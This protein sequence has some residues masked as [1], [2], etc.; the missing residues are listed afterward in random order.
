MPM[1]LPVRVQGW[2]A[3]GS[4][5]EELTQSEEASVGGAS[6]YLHRP[7]RHG[8][9]LQLSMPLPE[10]MRVRDFKVAS[11]VIHALVRGVSVH[12]GTC[13]ARVMFLARR[14]PG[15]EANPGGIY[16][17]PRDRQAAAGLGAAPSPS[18]DR[19]AAARAG[20]PGP[21]TPAAAAGRRGTVGPAA[22]G[23]GAGE[24]RAASPGAAADASERRGARRV[25]R[26]VNVRV[27]RTAVG[28]GELTI[29]ENISPHGARL[30]TTLAIA[31]GE[32]VW[33]EELHGAFQTRGEVRNAYLGPDR[34]LRLN[35]R[36]AQELP[37]STV[38][39]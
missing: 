3:D 28:S 38:N 29:A 31:A 5:W 9:V 19:T 35:V 37:A 34:I 4:G 20:F 10:R 11:Y 24:R 30:L 7:V 16:L 22:V 6:F 15:W 23:P 36:F 14:P 12:G 32:E 39:G 18:P 8:Q 25:E 26:I 2:E 13:R 1:H 21:K 33:V 17:L 27:R